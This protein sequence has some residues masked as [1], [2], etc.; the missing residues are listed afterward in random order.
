MTIQFPQKRGPKRHS[1]AN[2]S[3]RFEAEIKAEIEMNGFIGTDKVEKIP[4]QKDHKYIPDFQLPNGI[5]IEVKGWFPPEDRSKMIA[6]KECNP[7]LDI[8]FIF[9]NANG[10]I[11]K[12]SKTTYGEWAEKHGFQ[13]ASRHLPIEWLY[14]KKDANA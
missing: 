10:K 2:G 5:L 3:S 7:D 13:Y 12:D 14:E 1:A 6:V 11:S 4:Y 9:L 8:R